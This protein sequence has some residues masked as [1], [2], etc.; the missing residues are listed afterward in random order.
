MKISTSS[1]IL[2][3]LAISSSSSSL[4]APAGDFEDAG[5]SPSSSMHSV[6]HGHP[7]SATHASSSVLEG[8]SDTFVKRSPSPA[9]SALDPQGAVSGLLQDVKRTVGAIPVVGPPLS[10]I[11]DKVLLAGQATENI[12]QQEVAAF[13]SAADEVKRILNQINQTMSNTPASQFAPAQNAASANTN[14]QNVGDDPSAPSKSISDSPAPYGSRGSSRCW[15]QRYGWH[16]ILLICL[17]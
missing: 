3:T 13:T 15:F 4:A 1:I 17:C 5:F 2:A 7:S 16:H 10:S 11:L 8:R 14:T 12:S 9:N 6:H